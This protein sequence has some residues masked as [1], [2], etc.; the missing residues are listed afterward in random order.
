[1]NTFYRSHDK[2]RFPD[3]EEEVAYCDRSDWGVPLALLLSYRALLA[4]LL[5]GTGLYFGRHRGLFL[6]V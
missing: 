4:L 2:Y 1:M 3:I 6:R 5:H